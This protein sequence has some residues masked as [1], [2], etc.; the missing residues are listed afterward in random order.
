MGLGAWIWL[1]IY[2]NE[3]VGEGRVGSLFCMGLYNTFQIRMLRM[4]R[5]NLAALT[6]SVVELGVGVGV[7]I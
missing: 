7:Q 5:A 3:F 6:L 1:S 2:C 4:E